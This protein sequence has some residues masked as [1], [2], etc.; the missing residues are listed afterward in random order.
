VTSD[1]L[2]N[3]GP[4]Q[5]RRRLL[6]GIWTFIVAAALAAVL[7]A[8]GAPRLSRLPLFVLLWVGALCLFEATS[9]TCVVLAAR[10]LRNMDNG[11]A[12]IEDLE[13]LRQLKRQSR[14]VYVRAFLLSS[15][16]TGVLYML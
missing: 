11:D 7:V 12:R 15:T 4:L 13:E 2:P 1:C 6:I 14:R 5:K 8:I 10:G 3:I 16:L 9:E